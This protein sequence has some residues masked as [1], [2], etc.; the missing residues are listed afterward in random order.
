MK[1][2]LNTAL[3][4]TLCLFTIAVPAGAATFDYF[5]T[6]D[7]YD[8]HHA[9]VGN[10]DP[11]NFGTFAVSDLSAGTVHVDITLPY[12]TYII[13]PFAL[14]LSLAGQGYID[15]TSTMFTVL[16]HG[17]SYYIGGLGSFTDALEQR[18]FSHWQLGSA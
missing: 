7:W 3:A 4:A 5:T 8:H 9:L 10:T 12:G 1:S 2:K 16:P 13:G 11:M 17:G 14:G 6:P 18:C 15:R